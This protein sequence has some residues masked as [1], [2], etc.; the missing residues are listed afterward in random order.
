M[1]PHSSTLAW[2]IPWMEDT[3]T[4]VHRPQRPAG[5]THSSTRGLTVSA[6]LSSVGREMGTCRDSGEPGLASQD[7]LLTHH[8]PLVSTAV[9]WSEVTPGD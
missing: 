3:A 5:S 8:G 6:W 9:P 4:P 7:Y 2:K 1:A